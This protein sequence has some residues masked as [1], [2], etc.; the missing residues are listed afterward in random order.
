M[1]RIGTQCGPILKYR[2]ALYI[3][4][5]W[6]Q[7]DSEE[8]KF[9][10][11]SSLIAAAKSGAS[12]LAERASMMPFG[13]CIYRSTWRQ[14]VRMQVDAP[15]K[16]PKLI[17]GYLCWQKMYCSRKYLC[18]Q[19][20]YCSRKGSFKD[21]FLYE[22]VQNKFLYITQLCYNSP[23]KCY[24]YIDQTRKNNLINRVGHCPLCSQSI[25]AATSLELTRP[26]IVAYIWAV[27]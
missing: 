6:L 18:W 25:R 26:H 8:A 16:S 2:T 17:Y 3:V 1:S 5:F 4:Y 23:N 9:Q 10:R 14:H 12:V 21:C 22:Y 19:K 11:P 24:T 7:G 20:I 13:S 27:H 15:Q